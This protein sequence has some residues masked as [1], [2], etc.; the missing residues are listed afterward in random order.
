MISLARVFVVGLPSFLAI[1]F[2]VAYLLPHP[3]SALPS[4]TLLPRCAAFVKLLF[5]GFNMFTLILC[6]C[7][8]G[9]TVTYVAAGA[10]GQ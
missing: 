9:V 2:A 5:Y 1:F 4:L 10:N 6:I 8:V 7:L 3:T